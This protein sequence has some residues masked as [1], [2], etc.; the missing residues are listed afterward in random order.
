MPRTSDQSTRQTTPP[1]A[2]LN[3]HPPPTDPPP[4]LLT[5]GHLPPSLHS[6]TLLTLAP[7]R[8]APLL[9][10]LPSP[11]RS[12]SPV[13]RSSS[14][15]LGPP[16]HRQQ[17]PAAA[18]RALGGGT[19][20]EAAAD[21]VARAPAVVAQGSAAAAEGE[22]IFLFFPKFVCSGRKN[23]HGK[24][25]AVCRTWQTSLCRP[26]YVVHGL[27]CVAHGKFFVVCIF[28]FVVCPWSRQTIEIP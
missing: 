5:P 25:F 24:V 16:L 13:V 27:S 23:S 21:G 22:A 6:G 10:P 3:R 19:V 1:N 11:L 15:V 28:V 2:I 26:I 18:A 4:P 17:A 14:G 9:P 8:A 20:G 7:G 12:P